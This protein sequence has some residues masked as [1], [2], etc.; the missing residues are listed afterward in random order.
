MTWS[1]FEY[2]DYGEAK[3]SNTPNFR[4]GVG[5]LATDYFDFLKHTQG[6]DFNHNSDGI[7][8]NPAINLNGTNYT[9]LTSALEGLSNYINISKTNGIGF[10]A[11][12]DGYDTYINAIATPDTPYD[13]SV[14]ALNGAINDILYNTANSQYSRIRDGGIIL[15]KSGTYKITDTIDLPPGIILMGEGFGTKLVNQIPISG[16]P[17]GADK[18]MFRIKAD[19][20]RT[21]DGGVSSNKFM[22]SKDV[23]ITNL[24]VA[25]NFVEPKFL[26]DLSYKI[27][28]NYNSTTPMIAVEE[29]SSFSSINVKFM[30]R[31]SAGPLVTNFP[32]ATDSTVPVS[33]GTIVNVENCFI[34]GFKTG[35]YFKPS[36]GINNYLYFTDNKVSVY[37]GLNSDITL[38]TNNSFVLINDTNAQITNNYFYNTNGN[39]IGLASI[40]PAIS[41]PDLQSKSRISALD[42]S[43]SIERTSN[44]INTTFKIFQKEPTIDQGYSTVEVGNNFGG[45][46]LQYF[47]S[48]K[49]ENIIYVSSDTTLDNSNS[50]VLVSTTS[51]AVT[52][53]LPT[54]IDG[55][56]L[57]IKDIGNNLSNNYLTLALG[58]ASAI[59]GYAGNR[60]FVTNGISLKLVGYNSSW[61]LI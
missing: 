8:I 51:N 48:G 33:T 35:I 49:V 61:Y 25:D 58:G 6:T 22:F 18:P 23:V 43:I 42:N 56:I 11:I 3:M 46:A 54:V 29:G 9:D 21:A 27:C 13:G 15:I 24:V 36:G 19:L 41:A 60:M 7:L 40:I 4:T 53:T 34:D 45:Q 30:G 59:E 10:V 2:I 28:R 17:Q 1:L 55:R 14:P 16:I 26:G 32:I 39:I 5:R 57:E 20:S 44:V 31:V 50:I 37:G 47:S 52:L 12:P 38:A